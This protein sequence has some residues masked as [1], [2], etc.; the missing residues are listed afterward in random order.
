MDSASLYFR[1]YYG[2]PPTVGS[3]PD[4][5]PVNAVRGFLDA[6]GTLIRTRRPERM[7]CALDASW[8]PAWRVALVPGYKAHRVA[9]DG[10]EQAPDALVSQVPIILRTL[11]ALGIATVGVPEFEADDVLATLAARE[12]GPVEVATGDRDLFQVV[13][14]ARAVRVLYFARGVA[15]L[16]VV[17][18]AAVLAR[19]GVPA[20][21]YPDLA[22]L[23]GDPSDGLPGVSGV[24]QKTAARLIAD[25]GGVDDILRALDEHAEGFSP[26]LAIK[27]NLARQY[28][29]AAL[30]VTTARVD[31]PVG[32]LD[33]SLS[34]QGAD[35]AVLTHLAE[36]YGLS[37]PLR[38]I[39]AAIED[40]TP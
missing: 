33:D 24:G 4:G 38:R 30:A 11:E 25:H 5:T 3:A 17:D 26:A 27:I 34:V 6:L 40:P 14:D 23:R 10:G 7:V 29:A 12:A 35:P 36:R 31:V 20:A 39:S 13:D 15:R 22:T 28:L 1:A 19:F 18:D 37:G 21:R 2:V 8:R 16:E 9:A 32:P